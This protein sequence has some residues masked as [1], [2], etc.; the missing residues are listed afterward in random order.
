[1]TKYTSEEIKNR[2]SNIGEA[3]GTIALEYIVGLEKENEK[4]QKNN[5]HIQDLIEAER[6]R[7]EECN[8][9]HLRDIATLEKENEELKQQVSY[10]KDN[11]RVARKDRERLQDDVANG[12]EEF[13][14]KKPATSLRLLAN[15]EVKE[16]NEKLKENIK[17]TRKKLF[18]ILTEYEI[19]NYDVNIH[20]FYK[21]VYNI[22]NELMDLAE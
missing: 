18:D 9:V 3:I 4:L 1:M 11:L 13:I 12:L 22:H 7:Q 10:L 6:Q 14:K 15:K 16:E 21:D 20:Q 8:N 5:K 2:L 17:N 19:G